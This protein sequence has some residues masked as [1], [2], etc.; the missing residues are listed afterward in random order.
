MKRTSC[1]RGWNI[2]RSE[3]LEEAM[4]ELEDGW[5]LLELKETEFE[6]FIVALE[7]ADLKKKNLDEQFRP[8][9]QSEGS[10]KRLGTTGRTSLTCR[11]AAEGVK[12]TLT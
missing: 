1:S 11:K 6:K 5:K 2:W 4:E 7:E 12:T 9:I 3:H 8:K 10:G